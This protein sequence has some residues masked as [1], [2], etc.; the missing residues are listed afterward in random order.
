MKFVY[1]HINCLIKHLRQDHKEKEHI[2][3]KINHVAKT[4]R[5]IL[6]TVKEDKHCTWKLFRKFYSKDQLKKARIKKKYDYINAFETDRKRRDTHPLSTKSKMID[7]IF[8]SEDDIIEESEAT[9]SKF[10]EG[11]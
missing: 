5:Q 3:S 6:L 2:A 1:A 7:L 4:T 8:L 11:A 9:S 10:K